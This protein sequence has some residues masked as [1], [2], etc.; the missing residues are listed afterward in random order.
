MDTNRVRRITRS[1]STVSTIQSV[2]SFNRVVTLAG[3][4]APGHQDGIGQVATFDNPRG[5]VM[6]PDNRVYV[7][8]SLQCRLRRISSALNVAYPVTCKTRLVDVLRPSGCSLY[9]PP[10]N[11]FDRMGTPLA[12]NIYYQENRTTAYT[13]LPC[14]GTP[15]PDIGITTTGTA[16]T[17]TIS[18]GV[19]NES[20]GAV[21]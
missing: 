9:D 19:A 12:E 3:S 11:A 14:M 2:T 10:V 21:G 6:T 20:S 4:P 7:A 5:V 13:I 1:Y 15:P 8:D 16:S 18:G 17:A